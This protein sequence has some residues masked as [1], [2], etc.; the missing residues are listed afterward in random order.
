MNS[1]NIFLNRLHNEQI[2]NRL[3][4][5]VDRLTYGNRQ[6]I[7]FYRNGT[8]MNYCA[9]KRKEQFG[10]V[11]TSAKMTNPFRIFSFWGAWENLQELVYYLE[12][13]NIKL[14]SPHP[15]KPEVINWEYI[16]TETRWELPAKQE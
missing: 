16:N 12:E 5:S 7:V 4:R 8:T 6:E 1:N 10:L 11:E 14:T 9:Y 3:F 13:K 2:L 15:D